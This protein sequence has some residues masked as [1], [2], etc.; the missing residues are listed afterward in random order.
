MISIQIRKALLREEFSGAFKYVIQGDPVPWA[1]AVPAGRRMWDSQK[2][3]KLFIGLHLRRLHEDL[4]IFNEAL[5][6]DVMFYLSIPES[7]KKHIK[8][9]DPVTSVPD[10]SNCIK[11]IEDTSNKIL[12]RDDA[13]ICSTFNGKYY[14]K[15]PRTELILTPYS[16]ILN[17]AAG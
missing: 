15:D 6:M 12:F 1:R 2:E 16:K 10:L 5:H 4:P 17:K 9:G 14:S 13:I 11:F 3:K 7:R 8:E